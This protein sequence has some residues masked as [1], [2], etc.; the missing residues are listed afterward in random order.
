MG[1][2]TTD[3][4]SLLKAFRLY[5]C[6]REDP[7]SMAHYMPGAFAAWKRSSAFRTTGTSVKTRNLRYVHHL[8]RHQLLGQMQ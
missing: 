8:C 1:K 4:S 5:V 2:K 7:H 3:K 6:C